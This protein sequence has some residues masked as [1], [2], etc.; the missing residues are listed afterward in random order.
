M[1]N[2]KKVI[3]YS[4]L[5]LLTFAVGYIAW[6]NRPSEKNH[7]PPSTYESY[8]TTDRLIPLPPKINSTENTTQKHTQKEIEEWAASRSDLAAQWNMANTAFIGLCIGGLGL[9][10]IAWTLVETRSAAKSAA[11]TLDVARK[12][13]SLSKEISYAELRAYLAFS[14]VQIA[15]VRANEYVHVRMFFKN[16]GQTPAKNVYNKGIMQIGVEKKA[17]HIKFA[18]NFPILKATDVGSGNDLPFEVRTLKRL[19]QDQ[20]TGVIAD[21]L[22]IIC[23]GYILYDDIY[24]IQRRLTFKF[25]LMSTGMDKDRNRMWGVNPCQKGNR[26]N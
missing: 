15:P 3:L 9:F 19:T 6:L 16:T 1:K 20:L 17:N 7:N 18:K 10:F 2:I 14:H 25:R 11:D 22:Q 23:A 24:R 26:I 13:L 12:T 5:L 21:K 8:Q 4:F